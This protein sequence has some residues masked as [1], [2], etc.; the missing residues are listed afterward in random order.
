MSIF[1]LS[2]GSNI[3]FSKY[4]DLAIHKNIWQY[5]TAVIRFGVWYYVVAFNVKASG[6]IWRCLTN[7]SRYGS[8]KTYSGCGLKSST[9]SVQINS[10]GLVYNKFFIFDQRIIRVST[11]RI[12]GEVGSSIFQFYTDIWAPAEQQL[13]FILFKPTLS[14]QVSTEQG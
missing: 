5:V 4:L 14:F 12:N 3:W 7:I 9:G 1:Y 11:V 8:T 6:N 13:C 10:W 2:N